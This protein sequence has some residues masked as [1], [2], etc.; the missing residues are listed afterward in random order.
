[1]AEKIK[2][3]IGHQDL[4]SIFGWE[5]FHRSDQRRKRRKIKQLFIDELTFIFSGIA[6][7]IA[8]G[9]LVSEIPLTFYILG[10]L[11]LI[12]LLILAIEIII[13]ADLGVGG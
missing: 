4:E 6:A 1:M 13:Y 3:E 9:F 8:F 11:E 2:Q 7:L 5:T 10:G 12:L